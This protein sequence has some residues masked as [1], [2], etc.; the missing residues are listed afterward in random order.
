MLTAKRKK[1]SERRTRKLLR[2]C[3][4]M[5]CI[6]DDLGNIPASCRGILRIHGLLSH[7]H[8][9]TDL[10]T[11]RASFLFYPF[12]QTV[13]LSPVDLRQ[14]SVSENDV[15]RLFRFCSRLPATSRVYHNKLLH[16]RP[17]RMAP[18]F[19]KL[20]PSCEL[21]VEPK[22]ALPASSTNV[23]VTTE[24]ADNSIKVAAQDLNLPTDR[25]LFPPRSSSLLV[26][27]SSLKLPNYRDQQIVEHSP[28]P[29]KAFVF[30]VVHMY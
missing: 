10:A 18:L 12:H 22:A 19:N 2:E 5:V 23:L 17:S 16:F 11:K 27:D 6:V 25:S 26:T 21:E 28:L 7:R 13:C 29:R 20:L 24:Q 4:A 8:T 15:V 1:R 9:N 30:P 14:N 3:W